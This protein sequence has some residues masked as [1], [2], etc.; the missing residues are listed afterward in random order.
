M[1]L[2]PK[3]NPSPPMTNPTCPICH[4]EKVV[5]YD[6]T[7]CRIPVPIPCTCC[8]GTGRRLWRETNAVAVDSGRKG[9]QQSKRR[10][11]TRKTIVAISCSRYADYLDAC[12]EQGM[13][14][15]RSGSWARL[16][17]E[18]RNRPEAA[19]SRRGCR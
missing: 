17:H 7:G 13:V 1:G 14:P 2:T 8:D 12:R 4:G 9:G 10:G 16:R 18:Y 19:E 3:L 6:L 5:H 11:P 15:V